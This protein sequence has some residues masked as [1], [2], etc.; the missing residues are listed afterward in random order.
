[1]K[2]L[3]GLLI[4]LAVGAAGR[5]FGGGPFKGDTLHVQPS[6]LDIKD[7][8]TGDYSYVIVRQKA[9]D[10][11]AM[12]MILAKMSVERSTYHSRPGLSCDSSGIGI[13]WFTGRIRYSTRGLLRPYCMIRTGARLGI[14]WCLISMR[15]VLLQSRFCGLFRIRCGGAAR[16]SWRGRSGH[17]I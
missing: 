16:R 7:L 15:R 12:S 2:Y 8:Q 11:P 4:L 9:K 5:V 14:R 1:M 17:T 3:F 6:D 10:S 13:R